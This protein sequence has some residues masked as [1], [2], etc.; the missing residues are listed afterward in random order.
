MRVSRGWGI[1]T[2]EDWPYEG[3]AANWPPKEP[4]GIDRAAKAR[5]I[6]AYQRVRTL[7]D[8]KLLLAAET[9]VLVAL[10]IDADDWRSAT[11]GVIPMPSK[12]K[13]LRESHSVVLVG[14]N[15]ENEQLIV[16]NSWG[17]AWGDKGYGHIHYKYFNR[18][19]LEAWVPAARHAL[20]PASG[21]ATG[22][23]EQTWGIPDYFAST[24]LHGLELFDTTKDECV[25]WTLIVER[26]G[27]AEIEEFFVRPN[28]RGKGL[29]RRIAEMI[30]ESPHLK[31]RRLRLFVS[32]ADRQQLQ[33]DQS[34]KV[35]RRLGLSCRRTAGCKWS[36]IVAV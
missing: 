31:G 19:Q 14:Y 13:T 34:T 24:P 35:L 29:G 18:F 4:D 7:D 21:T 9:P 1:P 3:N 27:F 17:P 10:R 30:L 16:R 23:V 22:I 5:R 28:Y 25:G 2:E 12:F 20:R 15:D 33:S 32:H 36:S 8:C 6:L 11:N 26:S